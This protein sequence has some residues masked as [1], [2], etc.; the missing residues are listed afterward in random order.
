MENKFWKLTGD[1]TD[2][3]HS[4]CF[5]P[6]QVV[7][8]FVRN[9]EQTKVSSPSFHMCWTFL[10]DLCLMP[11]RIKDNQRCC[12]KPSPSRVLPGVLG[13]TPVG[14]STF[15]IL[16]GVVPRWICYD[17]V[18]CR[19][20]KGISYYF[21]WVSFQWDFFQHHR[22]GIWWKVALHWLSFLLS[23]KSIRQVTSQM[24][25]LIFMRNFNAIT[26]QVSFKWRAKK[27][28][29]Q[30]FLLSFFFFGIFPPWIYCWATDSM[31]LSG[32]S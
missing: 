27:H 9:E 5:S 17:F 12:C 20:P 32:V 15:L 18:G 28:S 2:F 31:V 13:G 26:C 1:F 24:P 29:W 10:S 16:R 7:I 6:L 22:F 11:K 21:H 3:L 25:L 23:F 19:I 30:F 4:Q 8:C 14:L